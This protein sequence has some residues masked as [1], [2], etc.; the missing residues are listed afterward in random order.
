VNTAD[1]ADDADGSSLSSLLIA[2]LQIRVSSV[3]IRGKKFH[4]EWFRERCGKSSQRT[5]IFRDSIADFAGE[6]MDFSLSAPI[7]VIRG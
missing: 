2:I 5:M 4:F 1:N 3:F 6:N 7:R